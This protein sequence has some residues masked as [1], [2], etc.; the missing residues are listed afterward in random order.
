[1]TEVHERVGALEQEQARID[2]RIKNTTTQIAKVEADV[3]ALSAKFE[4]V[5][6]N[7][8][9]LM[10]VKN[11]WGGIVLGVMFLGATGF[12]IIK[13]LMDVLGAK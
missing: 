12:T 4:K 9:R 13:F 6:E 1:M 2:E 3:L 5:I 7:Q 11:K 10:A 8:Q